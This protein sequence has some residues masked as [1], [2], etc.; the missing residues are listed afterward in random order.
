MLAGT[1]KSRTPGSTKDQ[2]P[3]IPRQFLEFRWISLLHSAGCSRALLVMG[4][5][6]SE[7]PFDETMEEQAHRYRLS[8]RRNCSKVRSAAGSRSSSASLRRASATPS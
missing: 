2:R 6:G 4:H 3:S 5:D 7:V 1:K 8:A